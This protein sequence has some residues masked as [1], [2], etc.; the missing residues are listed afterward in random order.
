MKV[1]VIPARGG[2]KRIPRKNI[3]EFCGRPLIAYSIA[4]ARA[5]QAFD[6]VLVS[7]DDDEIAAVARSYGAEVPFVRPA[8]LA[9][10][11]TPSM[12]VVKDAIQRLVATGV[13]VTYACQV[14]PTAPLLAPDLLAEGL[15]C[16]IESG[17]SFALGV[18]SFPFPIQ[19]GVRIIADGR[20]E[21]LWPELAAA[22]SQDLEPAFH[23]AGQ[24]CWG[25]VEA[26]DRLLPVFS[27]STV[28]VRIPR[29]LV[30]DIDTEEDWRHAELLYRAL[31]TVDRYG[32]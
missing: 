24:F 9:D 20:I 26:F 15:R 7:T 19:R 10:D 17:A 12:A 13:S 4:A 14:Y 18:T 2:S 8:Q 6:R 16:L 5:S 29:H 32:L 23:D 31:G 30:Q 28:A 11:Y 22:R 25:T 21:A 27:S 3:R 1:A